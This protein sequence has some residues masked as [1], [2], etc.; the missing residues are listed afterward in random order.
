MAHAE[1]DRTEP[2]QLV[3]SLPTGFRPDRPGCRLGT[4][5]ETERKESLVSDTIPRTRQRPAL[6]SMTLAAIRRSAGRALAA[7]LGTTLIMA[8]LL[9]S[10]AGAFSD[11]SQTHDHY[12][13]IQ[14]LSARVIINGYEDSTFRPANPVW[15]QHFAKMIVL[16]LKL[17]VSEADVCPFNDVQKGGNTDPYYPDNYIAVAATNGI[18]KGTT[19]TTFAPTADISRAQVITMVVRALDQ[20]WPNVLRSPPQGFASTWG[21]FSPTHSENARKAEYNRLLSGLPLESLDPWGGMPRA[22]VAQVLYNAINY[23]L[24]HKTI[25]VS[26]TG[27]HLVD[28]DKWPGPALVYAESDAVGGYFGVIARDAQDGWVADLVSATQPYTG[29]VPADFG[30]ASTAKIDVAALGSSWKVELRGPDTAR[31]LV[32]PG[33]ITGTGSEVVAVVGRPDALT[34]TGNPSGL[35]HFHVRTLGADPQNLIMTNG[36]YSGTTSVGDIAFVAV[37]ATGAWTITAV[38]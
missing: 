35:D 26:G 10:P 2:H 22:E 11:V 29:T 21:N 17:P 3:R 37:D 16:S 6:P 27:D 28:V 13:A 24:P 7:S 34:I 36:S 30:G 19:P 38:E 14:N 20:V 25:T 12:E 15:R 9:G 5:S 1:G 23:K 31:V 32:T 4:T 8:L 18:T 33:S